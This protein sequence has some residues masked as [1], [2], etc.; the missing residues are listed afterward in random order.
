MMPLF[1]RLTVVGSAIASFLFASVAVAD[2]FSA[3]EYLGGTTA[4]TEVLNATENLNVLLG[5][6]GQSDSGTYDIMVDTNGVK[7][8]AAGNPLPRDLFDITLAGTASSSIN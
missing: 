2:P 4:N 7:R 5:A 8:D 1:L 6:E 3:T